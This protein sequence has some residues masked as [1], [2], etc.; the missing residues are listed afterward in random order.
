MMPKII[1]TLGLGSEIEPSSLTFSPNLS[2][3][4]CN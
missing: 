1:E 3:L 4:S 2:L